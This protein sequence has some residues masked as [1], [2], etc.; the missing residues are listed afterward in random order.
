MNFNKKT[1]A[2]LAAVQGI[3]QYYFE[4]RN[5]AK[6]E[7]LEHEVHQDIQF[8]EEPLYANQ[9]AIISDIVNMYLD[10]AYIEEFA[11]EFS[12]NT[13]KLE[14]KLSLPYLQEL[15]ESV[16]KNLYVIDDILS[17][18]LLYGWSL[19]KISPLLLAIM[20]VAIAEMKFFPLVPSKVVINEFTNI[21]SQMLDDQ[22]VGFVN[23]VLDRIKEEIGR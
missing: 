14:F 9:Q 15:V 1:I 21:A 19:E 16:V 3:Y 13:E 18:F 20:R 11:S 6:L 12:G 2:R 4:N 22:E 5:T 23:K 7:I 8:S 10:P 17:K